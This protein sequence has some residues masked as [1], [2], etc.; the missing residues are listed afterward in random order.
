MPLVL[1]L[2]G[3]TWFVVVMLL[4]EGFL[5][6][7]GKIAA[8]SV[9]G[10]SD[11]VFER[12]PGVFEPNQRVVVRPRPELTHT[13]SINSLG[14]R[15]REISLEKTAG[16]FRILCL[17]DSLTHGDFVNDEGTL[18]YLLEKNLLGQGVPVEVINAGVGGTT[19]L[20]QAVFLKKILP[21]K[22]DLVLL[23]FAENDIFNLSKEVPLYKRMEVNRKL[24]SGMLGPIYA[25]V[26]DTAI[27]NFYLYAKAWYEDTKSLHAVAA[28][29]P[30]SG[31]E[32][33]HLWNIYEVE[34]RKMAAVLKE[35]DIRFVFALF[36]SHQSIEEPLGADGRL[37]RVRGIAERA[38]IETI[39]LLKPL[40]EPHLPK[41]D[42]YLLPYDGH[43]SVRAYTIAAQVLASH[44]RQHG[45]P[46]ILAGSSR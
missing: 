34:L 14:F 30:A 29:A 9:H 25:A 31:V 15:G 12:I 2:Y 37:E 33:D 32:S 3:L 4:L 21:M 16:T 22:P 19:I 46:Q 8:E 42:L 41:T 27:F 35:R 24:K 45:P 5:R 36:P 17:G 6:M 40:Q 26:R 39:N 20:D 13:V 44:L 43:P 11:A 28:E 7:Q 23:T 38:G 18:P 10:A 1:F